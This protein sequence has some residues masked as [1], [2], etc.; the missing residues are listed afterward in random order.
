MKFFFVD[1]LQ[2]V[3]R[4]IS[5]FN[6]LMD[7]RKVAVSRNCDDT[8]RIAVNFQYCLGQ[9]NSVHTGHLY[10]RHNNVRALFHAE[11]QRLH[12]VAGAGHQLQGQ[13]SLFNIPTDSFQNDLFIVNH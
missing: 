8:R 12:A 11:G 4:N 10:V 5:V 3:I 6:Q 7:I 1:G 2:N 13:I 9:L